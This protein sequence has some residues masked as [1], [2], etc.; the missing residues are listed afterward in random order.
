M[1]VT[2]KS[3]YIIALNR[4]SFPSWLVYSVLSCRVNIHLV[5]PLDPIPVTMKH[6]GHFQSLNKSQVTSEYRTDN[7]DAVRTILK[8]T[9][10]TT[11]RERRAK[12]KLYNIYIYKIPL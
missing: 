8:Q 9:S 2:L 5:V 7:S 12:M 3:T 4:I 10:T 6:E 11:K 1:C